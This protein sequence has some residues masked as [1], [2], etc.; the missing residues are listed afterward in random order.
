VILLSP[1][2]LS[3]E[4]G[5]LIINA[6]ALRAEP[7]D[8]L[9]EIPTKDHDEWE[10]TSTQRKCIVD[11]IDARAGTVTIRWL[12]ATLREVTLPTD[13]FLQRFRCLTPNGDKR[14]EKETDTGET[15][16]WALLFKD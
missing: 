6:T 14:F 7:P 1:E 11:R 15:T 9:S 5:S 16:G 8:R 4:D 10:E 12:F 3:E 13:Q 2:S